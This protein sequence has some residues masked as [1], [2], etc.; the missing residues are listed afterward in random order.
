[1]PPM[2]DG[3]GLPIGI[4]QIAEAICA[5]FCSDALIRCR[6]TGGATTMPGLAIATRTQE[7]RLRDHRAYFDSFSI[8]AWWDFDLQFRYEPQRLTL[9]RVFRQARD[10]RRG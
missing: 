7:Q 1:M 9:R 10:V 6:R 2:A 4:A 5:K 3:Y 8:P